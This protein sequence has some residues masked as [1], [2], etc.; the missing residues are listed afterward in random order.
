MAT[1]TLSTVLPLVAGM[2]VDLSH[3][4]KSTMEQ[5]LQVTRAPVIFS[6]SSARDRFY[7]TT[8]RLKRFRTKTFSCS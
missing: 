2:L 5:A 6:H 4:S 3:V 7:K 1:S 8:F